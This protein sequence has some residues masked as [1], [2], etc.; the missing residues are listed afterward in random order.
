MAPGPIRS[1]SPMQRSTA[2][3]VLLCAL[4]CAGSAAAQ[5]NTAPGSDDPLST[6][7]KGVKLKTDVGTM[8]DF[9]VKSRPPADSLH[10]IPIGSARP[11][12]ATPPLTVEEIKAE[13]A[14]LDALRLRHDRIAGRKGAPV[15]HTSVADGRKLPPKKPPPPKCILTCDIQRLPKPGSN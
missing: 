1:A 4:V 7:L 8:P 12:P 9:V 13:E 5:G 6:V 2:A 15:P 3:V 11:E 10:Y 14:K